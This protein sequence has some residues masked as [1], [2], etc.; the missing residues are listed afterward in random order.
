MNNAAQGHESLKSLFIKQPTANL[1]YSPQM[2]RDGVYGVSYCNHLVGYRD[3][4]H[5][6]ACNVHDF[7]FLRCTFWSTD[8]RW[9][10]RCRTH[11]GHIDAYSKI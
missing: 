2:S 5:D 4:D 8:Y 3:L 11:P 1:P 9:H 6:G 10:S 7:G